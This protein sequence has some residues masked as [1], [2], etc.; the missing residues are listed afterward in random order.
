MDVVHNAVP[1]VLSCNQMPLILITLSGVFL[2][3]RTQVPLPVYSEHSTRLRS[4]EV[5]STCRQNST[6]SKARLMETSFHHSPTLLAESNQ[7]LHLLITVLFFMKTNIFVSVLL[8]DFP[9]KVI[10]F[11]V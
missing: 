4:N 3:A 6:K 1:R 7:E 10:N 5:S 8:N 2:E 11:K 9:S